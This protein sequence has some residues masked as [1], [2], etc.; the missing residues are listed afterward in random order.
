VSSKRPNWFGKKYARTLE[1][2]Q[3]PDWFERNHREIQM[4]FHLGAR[5]DTIS[6]DQSVFNA[7]NLHYSQ[8]LWKIC[9]R[10]EIPMVYASSAATYGDGSLGYD[11]RSNDLLFKLKPLNP[12]AESKNEFDKWAV[13][14]S[15]PP[16]WVGLKFF[17]V[18]GPNE[19]HKGR[20]ASVLFHSYNQI[21]DS[22]KVILFKS[23]RS[24][25]ADGEQQRDF[26]Y[27]KDVTAVLLQLMKTAIPS[28]IYNLG[29]GKAQTFNSMMQQMFAALGLEPQIEY[30]PMPEDLRNRYQYFTEAPMHKLSQTELQLP[31]AGTAN[32]VADYVQ[33]FLVQDFARW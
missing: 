9:T 20:M 15:H 31:H 26:I 2:D 16:H 33:N 25:Y 8:S 19:Y 21:R 14:Q 28:G 1:R 17:N 12:Y 5:T 22:G 11:D 10:K 32:H 24:D 13:L 4:V 23:H 7:L 3:F 29:S 27:V 30:I 18:F 6:N